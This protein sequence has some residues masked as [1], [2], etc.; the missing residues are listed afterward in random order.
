MPTLSPRIERSQSASGRAQ[1]SRIFSK[2][3]RLANTRA[4]LWCFP[5]IFKMLRV[6]GPIV[7]RPERFVAKSVI[8]RR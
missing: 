5:L 2:L 1:G 6:A 7:E 8:F 4:L 3:L